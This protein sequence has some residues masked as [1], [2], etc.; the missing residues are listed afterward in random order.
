GGL[1]GLQALYLS[2]NQITA[3]PDGLATMAN[4]ERLDLRGN[5]I[6]IPPEILGPKE[7]WQGPGDIREILAYYFQ[8]LDPN[9]TAPLYEAKLI[10]VGEGGAGKT[11]LAKKLL[12]PDYELDREEKSTEGIDVLRWEFDQPNGIPFRANIWDFGGQ[13]IYHATHQ[14]FLTK[15]SL[16][17]LVVDTRQDNTDL[18]YWLNVVELLSDSSPVFIIKN[19]KQDRPCE[20]NERQLKGEFAD[21]LEKVL[22]TNLAD[23]RGLGEL[24]AALQKRIVDLPHVGTPLPKVWVRVRAALENYAA[25]RNTITFE[26]YGAICGTCQLTD[27]ARMQSLSRYLHDLGVILHFHDDAILKHTVILKPEWGTAAVYKVLDTPEVRDNFGRFSR[28]QLEEIWSDDEYADLR[29]ELLQ[30][31]MRFKLC[32]E[33]P[34]HPQ[35]YIA[36]Q[37]LAIDKPPYDWEDHQNLLLRYHYEFMPKGILTRF[38]VEMHK[39]IEAQTLVWKSG[40]VLNNGSARAEVIELYHRGEIHIRVSGIR[41]KDLLTV[42]SHE[43]D[44]INDSYER[45]RVKKLIPCNCETCAGSQDPHFYQLEKLHERIHNGK[46][47]IECGQPPYLDV[48]IR[49]LIDEITPLSFVDGVLPGDDWSDRGSGGYSHHA[50]ERQKDTWQEQR[51]PPTMAKEVFLSYSWG[52]ES[53]AIANQIDQAFQSRGITI[54]RDKRD[55][56]FKGLIKEFM[57]RIGR[58]KCVIAVVDDKYLKSPNCMFELVQVA[59]NGDFYDRIFPI[60]INSSAKISRGSDR[61]AYIKHWQDQIDE[62]NQELMTFGNAVKVSSI[63]EELNQFEDIRNT[64]DQLTYLLKNMNT[65]TLERHSESGFAELFEAIEQRLNE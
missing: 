43:I 56:G 13:E 60:V 47:T 31:M 10:I 7:R 58:G 28:A 9:E 65:L 55:L 38:I 52:G 41:Q 49:P 3:L 19:E 26:E 23:N 16:Y 15:R 20:V 2:D 25:T 33:I 61:L 62:L 6:P 45:L 12:D 57:Q 36:P 8:T 22:A 64:I 50:I 18:Y 42:I 17:V 4:L 44:Q 32:Y 53:E 24:K 54:V 5:P 35:H 63:Q 59:Q 40:V 14:F 46:F 30:L 27:K 21:S 34:G 37:L 1:T 29:D 48:P 39:F 11:T 51:L